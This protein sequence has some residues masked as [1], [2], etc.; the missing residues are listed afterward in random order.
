MCCLC[1]NQRK[2]GFLNGERFERYTAAWLIVWCV[3]VGV[4]V[5]KATCT[6]SCCRGKKRDTC[7]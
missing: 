1:T 7:V 3:K 6:C 2:E 5:K 4:S